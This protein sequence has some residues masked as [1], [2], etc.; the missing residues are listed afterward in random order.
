MSKLVLVTGAGQGIGR[1]IAL[2]LVA[3]GYK[4]AGCARGGASLDEVKELFG[5]TLARELEPRR[6]TVNTVAP[7]AVN[8]AITQSIIDAGPERAGRALFDETQ[9]QLR[10]GGASPAK[11]AAL[12]AYLLGDASAPVTGRLIS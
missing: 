8:T 9:K 4:V 6:I 5:G 11:A 10:E 3:D 12:A 1:A 2:K 7:G